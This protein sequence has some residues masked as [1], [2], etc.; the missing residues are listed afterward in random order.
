[1]VVNWSDLKADRGWHLLRA[2]IPV[3]GRA[4]T[5][6]DR[7]F[8]AGQQGSPTAEKRC[9]QRSAGVLPKDMGPIVVT[10]AGF[11]APWFR[12]V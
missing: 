9:L 11:R 2:A 10:D 7:V 1:M 8:P 6:L 12:A 5:M 4:L 3:G